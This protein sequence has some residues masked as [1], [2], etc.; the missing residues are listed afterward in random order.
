MTDVRG[1]GRVVCFNKIGRVGIASDLASRRRP[2]RV[3]SCLPTIDD[4]RVTTDD[5]REV[6]GRVLERDDDDDDDDAV[7]GSATNGIG[8]RSETKR[9]RRGGCRSRGG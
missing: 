1:R 7:L 5:W 9:R 2:H 3:G 4:W 8:R 6:R